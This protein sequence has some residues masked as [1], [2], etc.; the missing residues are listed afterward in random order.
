MD[1]L[2]YVSHDLHNSHVN[3]GRSIENIMYMMKPGN[4]MGSK[5]LR[6]FRSVVAVRCGGRSSV[7]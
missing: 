5:L 1:V 4:S 6:N 3:N 7:K 2:G